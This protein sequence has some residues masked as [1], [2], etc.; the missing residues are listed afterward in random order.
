[1]KWKKSNF[2]L[3]GVWP[4]IRPRQRISALSLQSV[5]NLSAIGGF[6]WLW[7][8]FFGCWNLKRTRKTSEEIQAE[9]GALTA[10]LHRARVWIEPVSAAYAHSISNNARTAFFVKMLGVVFSFL[11]LHVE[12]NLFENLTRNLDFYKGC[13]SRVAQWLRSSGRRR[14]H[15]SHF[16]SAW[17]LWVPIR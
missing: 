13:F 5:D 15:N 4:M 7:F 16:P 8:S 6:S 2:Y 12:I 11:N 3:G 17:F 1:M 14:V 9:I 10:L